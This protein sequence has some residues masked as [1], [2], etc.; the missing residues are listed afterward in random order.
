MEG[1]LANFPIQNLIKWLLVKA[2]YE[3]LHSMRV[4]PIQEDFKRA[5]VKF[6]TK[7]ILSA[8]NKDG[9]RNSRKYGFKEARQKN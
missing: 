9:M 3:P 2:I 8:S 5:K 4:A 1:C 6:K 7:D